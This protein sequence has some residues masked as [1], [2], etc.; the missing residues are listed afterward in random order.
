MLPTRRQFLQGASTLLASW[1]ALPGASF[2]DRPVPRVAVPGRSG[3]SR[4]I[5][6]VDGFDLRAGLTARGWQRYQW[7]DVKGLAQCLLKPGQ[8]LATTKYFDAPPPGPADVRIRQTTLVEALG[9]LSAVQVFRGRH[10]AQTQPDASVGSR[11]AISDTKTTDVNLAVEL[12]RDAFLDRFDTALLVS[13][14][15]DLCPAIAA[16]REMF[17]AKRIVVAFPPHR[18]SGALRRA[19]HAY[20]YIG[21]DKLVRS[22][23][24]AQVR[25]IDGYILRRPA[26]W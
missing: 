24:P 2:S 25:R 4:V 8:E 13:A 1:I 18:S 6:Y 23:L 19:A 17:P 11:L 14:D 3:P 21:R 5:A 9:T 12:L 26:G 10:A 22:T 7:L 20:L 16:C 15:A